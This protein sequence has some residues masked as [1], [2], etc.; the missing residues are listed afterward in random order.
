LPINANLNGSSATRVT[1]E[2]VV[3]VT[4]RAGSWLANDET[5]G[6]WLA[7][8]EEDSLVASVTV[9]LSASTGDVVT[10]LDVSWLDV[11]RLGEW[12]HSGSESLLAAKSQPHQ[13][14]INY[15]KT[16]RDSITTR[17]LLPTGDTIVD[18]V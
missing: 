10:E 5:A 12:E 2:A 14:P 3:M 4:E 15:K 9:S 16:V 18:D 13:I 6:S 1:A 7:D 11:D 8:T 17:K